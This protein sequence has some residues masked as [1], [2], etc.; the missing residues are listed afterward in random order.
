M[1][2]VCE[3]PSTEENF[4]RQRERTWERQEAT[5]NLAAPNIMDICLDIG[6]HSCIC[7]CIRLSVSACLSVCQCLCWEKQ[8]KKKQEG[9]GGGTSGWYL[10][11]QP[12]GP[13]SEAREKPEGKDRKKTKKAASGQSH[14]MV[15][16]KQQP[17]PSGA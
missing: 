2:N 12:A 7:A 4:F 9:R 3:G 15:T 11:I 13:W 6:V 17:P 5:E 1:G 8:S 16:S 14:V 10:E